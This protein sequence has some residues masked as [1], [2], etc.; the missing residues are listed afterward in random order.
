MPINQFITVL[1]RPTYQTE[2]VKG[3]D[4]V[5]MFKGGATMS[6]SNNSSETELITM[7][8]GQYVFNALKNTYQSNYKGTNFIANSSALEDFDSFILK[9]NGVAYCSEDLFSFRFDLFD[10]YNNQ[11]GGTRL[12]SYYGQPPPNAPGPSGGLDWFDWY[13]EVE[14]TF[15]RN[16]GDNLLVVNGNYTFAKKN[17]VGDI[18]IVPICGTMNAVTEPSFYIDFAPI[19]TSGANQRVGLK[20]VSLEFIE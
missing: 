9:A 17:N 2:K 3:F 12:D 20:S 13:M 7:I 5:R 11:I 4:R 15:Y 16:G 1:D 18:V 8:H 6:P 19:Y 14:F 10:S